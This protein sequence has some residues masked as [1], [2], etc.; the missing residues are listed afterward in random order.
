[1]IFTDEFDDYMT[2]TR[3][4]GTTKEMTCRAGR[5]GDLLVPLTPPHGAD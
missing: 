1:M 4:L 3:C 5:V 2:L